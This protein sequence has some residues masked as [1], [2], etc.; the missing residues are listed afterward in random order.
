MQ[1]VRFTLTTGRS[2]AILALT[3]AGLRA[4]PTPVPDT[5]DL[6]GAIGF[7]VQNNFAIRQARERIKQQDGVVI[8]VSAREIPNV[9]ATGSYQRNATEITQTSP[10]S[11]RYWAISLTATQALFAGGGIRSAVKSSELTR[12]AALLDL[13]SVINDALLGVRTT[14]YSVL[15]AR[16]KIIVQEK[17]LDLLKQQLKNVSNRFDAGTVSSF[18]KLRASMARR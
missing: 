11:D 9:A 12:E 3:L 5:L 8:E 2:L 15:L 13:K 4:E 1:P 10:A 6:K 14:F 16:E 17:N 7:A 18:E